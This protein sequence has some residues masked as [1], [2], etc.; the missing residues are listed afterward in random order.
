MK[1][2]TALLLSAL[3]LLSLTACGQPAEPPPFAV[4]QEMLDKSVW[5]ADNAVRIANAMR[6][7]REGKPTTLAVFGGSITEGAAATREE[8]RYANRV[9]AW[10]R[11][12]FP[13]SAVT[14]VNA[15]IGA[16]NTAYGVHRVQDDVL[17]HE[18]DL[19]LFEFAANDS[20]DSQ[21]LLGACECCLRRLL[22]DESGCGV[23][24]FFMATED[25]SSAENL[26]KALGNYYE[27]PMLSYKSA[28]FTADF[29][30]T[31]TNDGVHPTSEGHGRAALLITDYLQSVLD[32][33]DA[34]GDTPPALPEK[35][36]VPNGAAYLDGYI[37]DLAD[38]PVAEPGAFTQN[39][40]I[41]YAQ[42]N[43]YRGYT[44]TENGASMTFTVNDCKT[45]FLLCQHGPGFG[46][47]V[48]SVADGHAT[49]VDA[50]ADWGQY[51]W[52]TEQLIQS[53]APRSVTVT[54]TPQLKEG[55]RFTV[56][57]LLLS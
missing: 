57:A 36:L 43:A 55:E 28:Y 20:P 45:L 6:R 48:I 47:A 26:Q 41:A 24:L 22:S 8:D 19:V 34:L 52:A 38:C 40:E 44:A 3:P 31:Q 17:A 9:A 5:A 13:E 54:V 25:G 11:E 10:W 30:H 51:M 49:T 32:R 37:R 35:P 42:K 4:T 21:Q 1:R 2:W 39:S 50:S 27:L 15:G 12:T 7:A 29:W 16:T 46:S 33:L 18:P 56:L 23:L 53:D 14:L